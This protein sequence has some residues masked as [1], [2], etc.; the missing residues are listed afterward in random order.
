MEYQTI[1]ADNCTAFFLGTLHCE[2]Q[3][4]AF[5]DDKT[6][7]KKEVENMHLSV[8]EALCDGLPKCH[9]ISET[10]RNNLSTLFYDGVINGLYPDDH[11]KLHF[12]Y[13]KVKHYSV[14]IAKDVPLFHNGDATIKLGV[15]KLH[16]YCFPYGFIIF[17]LEVEW[18]NKRVDDIIIQC[19]HIRNV[20]HYADNHIDI[21]FLSL[22]SPV[23]TL[24][25]LSHDEYIV[26]NNYTDDVVRRYAYVLHKANKLKTYMVLHLAQDEDAKLD[27]VYTFNHL[28]YDVGTMSGVGAS[29]DDK[30]PFSPSSHYFDNIMT[31]NV[32]DCFG[33]WRALA[34]VDSFCVLMLPNA[35]KYQYEKMWSDYYFNYMYVNVIYIKSFM[36]DMNDRYTNYKPSSQIVKE[37]RLFDRT[38]NFYHV[39]YNFLPRIIYT[40]MRRGLE[41]DDE[42]ASVQR[43]IE[44]YYEQREHDSDKKTNR[45]LLLLTILSA[46]ALANDIWELI[47]KVIEQL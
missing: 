22:F 9:S 19:R 15:K 6:Q 30:H 29:N 35:D 11:T 31:N 45:F 23:L 18:H 16:F 27:S 46:I 24:Y 1:I 2:K 10:E 13:D 40:Y 41:L 14:G 43:Q 42:L 5:F 7:W 39:S 47:I 44:T 33:N 37:F 32:V 34:L 28:L 36:L 4:F 8:G 38:F 20:Y 26:T 25:N 17:A 3:A 12:P 21:R